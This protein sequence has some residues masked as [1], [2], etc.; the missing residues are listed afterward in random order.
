MKLQSSESTSV[1]DTF[2]ERIK[3]QLAD[4][5]PDEQEHILS[6]ARA[7]AELELERAYEMDGSAHAVQAVLDK[8]G[9]PEAYARR[10]RQS[11]LP[12]RA[13]EVKPEATSEEIEPASLVPC[14]SCRREISREAHMCPHCG[15]P[16]PARKL[17]P[18]SGYEWKS[19]ATLFGWPLVHVAFGRDKNGKLRVAK[20]V[21]AIGQFGV[22]A[23]TIAQFGVGLIFGLGQFTIAPLA[24][25][26]FAAGLFAAGQ[27]GLGLLAGAGQFATGL[28]KSWGL[29][30]LGGS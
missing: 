14:R 24:V 17:A 19:K 16:F 28:W 13:D 15:A 22:G 4:L 2:L 10:L 25:G 20:G 27:F 1:V 30:T 26:Q 6:C 8:L 9:Q 18:A 12:G 29:V 3:A 21:I 5:S 7:Q 11:Q 23:I